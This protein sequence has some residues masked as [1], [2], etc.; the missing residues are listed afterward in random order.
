M[1]RLLR[2]RIFR[3]FRRQDGTA[4]IEFVLMVPIVLTIFMA[5]IEAGFYMTKH[6]MMERGLDIVMRDLR[7]GKLGAVDHNSLR[8]KICAASL[9][10][11]DCESILKVEMRPV[12]TATFEMPSTPATCIDRGEETEP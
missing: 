6:V 8:Q 12:S 1:I 4:T 9:I 10:M 11:S 7:L 2:S 5:S 3:A